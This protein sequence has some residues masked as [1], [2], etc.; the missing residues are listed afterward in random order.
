MTGR[1]PV[2]LQAGH[3]TST[4]S[5]F[6]GLIV[7]AAPAANYQS[8]YLHVSEIAQRIVQSNLEQQG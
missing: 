5:D 6:L 1:K 7:R 3:I 4:T 8:D 2:P